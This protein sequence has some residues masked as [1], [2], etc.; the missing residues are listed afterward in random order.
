MPLGV[1]DNMITD[2]TIVCQRTMHHLQQTKPYTNLTFDTLIKV[3]GIS[4][5]KRVLN[6]RLS[7]M[8]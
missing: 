3:G 1:L 8:K 7:V 5:D 4:K 6:P 2:S